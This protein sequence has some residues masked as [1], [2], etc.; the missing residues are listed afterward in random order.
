[1][2]NINT[3]V[4]DMKYNRKRLNLE[5][6]LYKLRKEN[7][8]KNKYLTQVLFLQI[9][10]Q[11]NLNKSQKKIFFNLNNCHKLCQNLIKNSNLSIL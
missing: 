3:N 5:L 4:S 7:K 1:M 10:L 11:L 6:C 9:F 2:G 8:N